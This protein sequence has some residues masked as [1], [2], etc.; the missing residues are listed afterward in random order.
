MSEHI[1]YQSN[2]LKSFEP[3][4]WEKQ[5]KKNKKANCSKESTIICFPSLFNYYR[6]EIVSELICIQF[7]LACVVSLFFIFRI[8]CVLL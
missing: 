5:Q 1:K 6:Q 3:H 2:S 4:I 8:C 7:Y